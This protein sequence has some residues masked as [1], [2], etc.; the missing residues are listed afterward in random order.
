MFV[1]RVSE[2]GLR[3]GGVCPPPSVTCMPPPMQMLTG[4][5]HAECVFQNIPLIARDADS[6]VFSSLQ[7]IDVLILSRRGVMF[8]ADIDWTMWAV[9]HFVCLRSPSGESTAAGILIDKWRRQTTAFKGLEGMLPPEKAVIRLD[10]DIHRL[11]A[12]EASPCTR[13]VDASAGEGLQSSQ[14]ASSP[15]IGAA[16][17]EVEGL[18]LWRQQTRVLDPGGRSPQAYLVCSLISLQVPQRGRTVRH[19]LSQISFWTY[20]GFP[21]PG[22]CSA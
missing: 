22:L 5:C 6:G 13:P 16:G 10:D 7:T 3:C 20:S 8:D 9:R 1:L 12:G 18:V 14:H 21:V 19:V 4:L 2:R 15:V 17:K 11:Y